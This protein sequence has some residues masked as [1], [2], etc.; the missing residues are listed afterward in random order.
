[1][2]MP[3]TITN[4]A[5]NRSLHPMVVRIAAQVAAGVFATWM[6]NL[7]VSAI[8]WRRWMVGWAVLY[9]VFAWSFQK[10]D[11]DN[12]TRSGTRETTP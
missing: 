10:P 8:P 12:K 3:N 9:N 11:S 4:N 1:M 6:W 7:D 2:T 5:E